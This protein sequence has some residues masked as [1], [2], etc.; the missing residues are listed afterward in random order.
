MP[1]YQHGSALPRALD[2]IFAQPG[3]DRVEVVVSNNAST[4]DTAE[5]LARYAAAHPNLR[6]LAQPETVSFDENLARAIDACTGDYVWT[7][8]SDD[9]LIDGALPRVE[10]AL[11]SLEAP[12][13]VMG[14]WWIGDEAVRPV[15]LRRRVA[16][17]RL[18]RDPARSVVEA[19]VW[20]L[21]M[22]VL[23]LPA[24]RTRAELARY[25]GGDGLTH[26]KVATRLL[27]EGMPLLSIGEPIVVQRWPDTDAPPYYDVPLI[28]GEQVRR[29]MGVLR[30][31]LGVTRA[32]ARATESAVL[33]SILR[34]F[35][36]TAR[37]RWPAVARRWFQPLLHDYWSYPAFWLWIAPLYGVPRGVLS[38]VWPLARGL[39]DALAFMRR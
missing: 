29:Q 28:F 27:A 25:R 36:G 11:A 8:S 37:R 3:G 23:L 31:D 4:D 18:E 20:G 39:R 32:T 19:G 10:A 24:E 22:S 12:A 16:A 17:D 5:V 38:R 6:V 15:R 30:R 21:F 7:L 13:V 14:N 2:S 9:V 26:W 1:T 35:V 34:G 33:H